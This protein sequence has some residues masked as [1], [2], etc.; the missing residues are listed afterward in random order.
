M[1]RNFT[2]KWMMLGIALF[3][4]CGM[5]KAQQRAP[6]VPGRT[7]TEEARYE[8]EPIL[9]SKPH[10]T[11]P[12]L[13]M[14]PFV[15]AAKSDFMQDD[16]PVM[17][18]AAH[19]VAKAYPVW[20]MPFHEVINDTIGP[21]PIV[22][23]WCQI[24]QSGIVY[25]RK[26]SGKVLTFGVEG[27]LWRDNKVL[28]DR[29]T[30]SL[31]SQG[32]GKGI[33][34]K[35]IETKLNYYSSSVMTWKDWR[36]LHP[37][38]EVLVKETDEDKNGMT[39]A[40][41]AYR[42]DAR[43]GTTGRSVL[44]GALPSKEFV[45]GFEVK[46]E[47]FVVSINDLKDRDFLQTDAQ[48]VSVVVVPTADRLSARVYLA[49]AH[50][51]AKSEKKGPRTLLIDQKTGSSWDGLEGRAITGALKG[52]ELQEVPAMTSFWFAQY[53]FNPTTRVLRP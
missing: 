45:V 27:V 10:D 38:T 32:L 20:M 7:F 16:E 37:E 41:K 46:G 48:G 30:N 36:E 42:S 25:S 17:G 52:K 39:E 44:G 4:L 13:T 47:P 23:T 18:V 29:Q 28:F 33:R 51:F 43:V 24:C 31:W 26:V 8:D 9:R 5:A 40:R 21:D 35:Y 49:G 19:G 14:P 11:V 34:G 15:P 2:T 1:N 53:T 6:V 50:R 12:S 22:I 3:V